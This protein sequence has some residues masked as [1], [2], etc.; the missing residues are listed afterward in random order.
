M[1]EEEEVVKKGGSKKLI[2]LM[3]GA[4]LLGGAGVGG[5]LYFLGLLGGGEGGSSE[6]VAEKVPAQAEPIYFAFP[7]PFTVNFE[8]PKGVR[9]LQVSIEMMTFDQGAVDAL[10]THLPVI[11]NNVILVLSS[12]PYETL[13]SV[14]G[15][16]KIRAEILDSIR[17]V[18]KKYYGDPGVEEIYFTS[19]VMQ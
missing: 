1:A 8:T 12:Q 17:G 14:E 6:H 9:F 2:I 3:L 10:Q 7:Q 13:I 19:F 16:Q 11:T 4:L 15:K 5:T 18:L